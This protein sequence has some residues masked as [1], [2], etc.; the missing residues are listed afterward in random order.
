M[1]LHDR[2]FEELTAAE[3]HDLLRLRVDVFVVEQQCAYGELDGRDTEPGTR[4]VWLSDE[5]GVVSYT[6]VLADPGATRIGRVA[7]RAGARG[8]GLSAR[9][10]RPVLETTDGPWVLGA[11]T[12]LA[13]WY[14]RF[15]FVDDGEPY[16]ED[17]IPHVPMRR[18]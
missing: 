14:R 1:E 6:R 13:D 16:D 11:Q 5:G 4:H 18:S 9:L 8:A 10:L 12:Y 7:T 3:L 15:G 17:G 2:A